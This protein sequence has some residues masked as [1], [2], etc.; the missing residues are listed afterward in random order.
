MKTG[1]DFQQTT[2]ASVEFSAACCRLV[3]RERILSRV[4][5]PAPFCPMI[6]STSPG[7][8]SETDVAQGP[9]ISRSFP[10]NFRRRARETEPADRICQRLPQSCVSRRSRAI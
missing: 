5:L 3:M 7:I 2:G 6:P 10:K 1:S 4:D 9:D 8:D